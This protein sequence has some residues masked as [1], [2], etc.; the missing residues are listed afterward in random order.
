MKKI[1]CGWI[2]A[3]FLF[4]PVS[5]FAESETPVFTEAPAVSAETAVVLE[6]QTGR[7]LYE[8]NCT[9]K[10]YP[11]ST[12]K[13]MTALLAIEDGDLDQKIKV[14]DHAVGTEGSSIYLQEGE[15]VL[16]K[17]LVYG[18]MLRSGNDAAVAIAEGIS[19]DV[20]TFVGS[21]N[22]RAKKIGTAGTHFVNPNGLFDENHYT[23]ALDMALIA[24]TAMMNPEFRKVAAA[25]DWKASREDSDYNYFTN[26]NKVVY[27]YEGGTGIKIG[28]TTATGRTLVASS[29]RDGMEVICVVMQAPDWFRDSYKLM[30]WAYENFGLQEIAPAERELCALPT[31]RGRK[32]HVLIGPKKSILCPVKKDGSEQIGMRFDL[33]KRAKG[34]IQRWQ[35]AGWLDLSVNGEAICKQKLYYLEDV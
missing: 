14:S 16:L 2:T 26:K 27:Q 31:Q 1:V 19:G 24:R 11:A 20:E 34:T 13:I 15:R 28:Y 33:P 5:V 6:L 18:L 4:A 30:D 17:D 8:K 10:A 3:L 23:T 35:E 7:I 29:E 22:E 21:M 9:E 32:D 12:T 25:K